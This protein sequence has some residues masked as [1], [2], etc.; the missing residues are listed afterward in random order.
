MARETLHRPLGVL[1][2]LG[3][4]ILKLVSADWTA[5]TQRLL[6]L[7]TYGHGFTAATLQ[8]IS[9]DLA[10]E[11][12]AFREQSRLE[13]R[14]ESFLKL[15][16]E[17]QG[18][19][20]RVSYENAARE[21]WHAAHRF[22]PVEGVVDVLER[23]ASY[24]VRMGVLSNSAFSGQVLKEELEKHDLARFFSFI[25]SSADFGLRKPNPRLIGLAVKKLG[26]EAKDV[27]FV[28]DKV[29]IDVAGGRNA[30]LYPVW[31]NPK[32]EPLPDGYSCA[33]ISHWSEFLPLFDQLSQ[34]SS[35]G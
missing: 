7:A 21:L 32:R 23:L 29:D 24:R 8:P 9:S 10:V 14:Y 12:F 6:D 16:R 2:D 28:G 15:L 18:I 4:T 31:Y 34:G 13:L 27:W 26:L 11:L 25:H 3:D 35:N 19:V 20:L 22:E 5:G 17:T 1:F 33:E 30:G